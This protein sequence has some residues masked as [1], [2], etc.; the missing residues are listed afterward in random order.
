M[1]PASRQRLVEANLQ[2]LRAR[3]AKEL[4][5]L[6]KMLGRGVEIGYAV[7]RGVVVPGINSI[8]VPL[9]MRGGLV[10]GSLTAAGIEVTL[11]D[12]REQEVV[13]RLQKEAAALGKAVSDDG[14]VALC[15]S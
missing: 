7:S 6:R 14:F 11:D 15:A 10:F 9:R 8:G 12:A 5:A 1:E 2:V 4:P 13:K 3:G